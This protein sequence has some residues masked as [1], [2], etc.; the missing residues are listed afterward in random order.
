[1]RILIT[2]I[3]GF[4]GRI[5]SKELLSQGNE[6]F[7]ID[8][9]G[10]S[11]NIHTGDITDPKSIIRIAREI[12]PDII[13]HLAAISKVDF[14]DPALLYTINVSGT[15]NVLTAAVNCRK[16]P[17]F[18][19]V[20]SSQVYGIVD[21]S[22]QPI[23]EDISVNPVNHYGAS[24][25]AG[26]SLCRAFMN[27][28]GMPL[29]I[30]RPFN[31]IGVGQDPHFVVPKIIQGFKENVKFLNL[32]NI[33]TERDFLD[34][35]DVADAY[36]KIMLNFKSGSIYNISSGHGIKISDIIS[37]LKNITN[38]NIK[39]K[40]EDLLLRKNEIKIS[41]GNSTKLKND[42][43]WENR[44]SIGDTLNWMLDN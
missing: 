16:I 2:G 24:K 13:I 29:V 9:Q 15:L 23:N 41:I 11:S 12:E 27:E 18:L 37:K 44:H 22:K 36:M 34:V 26:E 35:R 30:A 4:V 28:Y 6:V 25:A 33:D 14:K 39:I 20:S 42:L 1:M 7:G 38:T 5:L 40:K 32:G 8:I 17:S 31:H 3:N 43:G 10:N 21:E 19:Y